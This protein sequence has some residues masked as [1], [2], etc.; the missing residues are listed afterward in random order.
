MKRSGLG[1]SATAT[2]T[3]GNSPASA[4]VQGP[5]TVAVGGAAWIG[6]VKLERSLDAG[7]SWFGVRSWTEAD[8]GTTWRGEDAEGGLYRFN[9]TAY[10]SGTIVAR[11]DA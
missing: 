2:G 7:A 10:T 4:A 11:I 6:T 9:V 1:L 5:Y 3:A 8:I